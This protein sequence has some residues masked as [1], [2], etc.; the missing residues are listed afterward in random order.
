MLNRLKSRLRVREA[1]RS[2]G[3]PQLH[4]GREVFLFPFFVFL[5]IFFVGEAFVYDWCLTNA[6]ATLQRTLSRVK[7]RSLYSLRFE[8]SDRV[9]SLVQLMD[10][11][12]ELSRQ[13]TDPD[14]NAT[15]LKRFQHN[16]RLSG[17]ILLDQNLHPDFVSGVNYEEWKSHIQTSRIPEVV[18]W[19]QKNSLD[20]IRLGGRLYDYAAVARRDKPGVV[21]TINAN[22]MADRK[23]GLFTLDILF[24]DD[25]FLLDSSV[26]ITDNTSIL[27]ANDKAWIGKPVGEC[28]LLQFR[29]APVV[30]KSLVL[31]RHDGTS[32]YGARTRVRDLTVYVFSKQSAVI[33]PCWYFAAFIL[34]IYAVLQVVILYLRQHSLSA[35]MKEVSDK[36]QTIQ[37]ISSVY[38]DVLLKSVKDGTFEVIKSSPDF[39]PV[40]EG[41]RQVRTVISRMVRTIIDP[42]YE[43]AYLEF[44]NS[45]TV[46]NRLKA[47]TYGYID[48]VFPTQQGHWVRNVFVAHSY[49]EDGTLLKYLSLSTD[50]TE[51]KQREI[52]YQEKLIRTARDAQASAI[53]KTNFL[54][55]MSHD[56]RTPINGILGMLEIADRHSG[57]LNRQKECRRHIREASLILLEL[58]N[59]VLDLSKLDARQLN[60]EEK[61]FDLKQLWEETLPTLEV[62]SRNRDITL[63]TDLNV[64]HTSVTGCQS[65]LRRSIMNIVTNAVKY[66]R[67]HGSVT[68]TLTEIPRSA[69]ESVYEFVCQDTGIGMSEEFQKH[70]FEPFTQENETA[71]TTYAGTGL[72]LAIS[73]RILEQLGGSISFVS[74]RNVGT[75]FTIRIPL[76]LTEPAAATERSA[77]DAVQS[78]AAVDH[79][80]LAPSLKGR[81]ILL[82]EDNDLNREIAELTL[83]EAGAEVVSARDGLQAVRR[84]K[85]AP[86][87]TF[88][89]ILMDL[90][91][92]HLSGIEAARAIRASNLPDAKVI[93][94]VAMTANIFPEDIRA[95]Q[96]AGMNAHIA[97]PC[98]AAKL[99]E[100]L[101]KLTSKDA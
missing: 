74:R 13:L 57:D 52:E 31:L 12:K 22:N 43:A 29:Y 79:A 32:W 71:R 94:I 16:M 97:K 80:V 62:L 24:P 4:Y 41:C 63:K 18:R 11:A 83:T 33:Y 51:E 20:R 3:Q 37:A 27:D 23:S 67:D 99:V 95:T 98:S 65:L 26:F 30:H 54:R 59:D 75:T 55:H 64:R 38:S 47:S 42:D 46:A 84:F 66:N 86:P 89:L 56:I 34:L 10:K 60:A 91:M 39:G 28:P 88:D 61:P 93:P 48:G 5:V 100:V 78:T 77:D 44:H 15:I 85:E 87:G 96:E 53:A 40:Y 35:R 50:V 69:G 76:K 101:V 90:M 17:V 7:E 8:D 19:P 9:N 58:I 82:A 73:K 1:L 21:I 6:D 14:P 92:P 81:R 68:L 2:G 72:G 25:S 70:A 49:A 36:L 45:D